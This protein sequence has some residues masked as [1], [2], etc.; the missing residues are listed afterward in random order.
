MLYNKYLYD[1]SKKYNIKLIVGTD[2]HAL[3]EKHLLGRKILQE[4][5]GIFFN[6][7]LT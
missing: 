1:L 2:T 3:D 5:K 7:L 4:A 6:M